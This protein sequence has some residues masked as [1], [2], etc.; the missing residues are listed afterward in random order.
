MHAD[1][2]GQKKKMAD[3]AHLRENTFF[4]KKKSVKR[5]NDDATFL[6]G[7]RGKGVIEHLQG[8]ASSFPVTF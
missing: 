3:N 5:K 4:T 6:F 2:V 7:D 8:L 1:N